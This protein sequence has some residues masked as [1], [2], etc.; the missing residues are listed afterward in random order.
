MI[1]FTRCPKCGAAAG[2]SCLSKLGRKTGPHRARTLLAEKESK[3]GGVQIV[4]QCPMCQGYGK[5]EVVRKV[6]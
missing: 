5:I 3:G 1:L 2:S 6:V 4:V